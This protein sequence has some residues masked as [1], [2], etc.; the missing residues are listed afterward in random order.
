VERS[1]W[2]TT[3]EAFDWLVA[4]HEG[5]P[6]WHWSAL[7]MSYARSWSNAAFAMQHVS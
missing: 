3:F 7:T 5:K 4:I 6:R 2:G 1:Q